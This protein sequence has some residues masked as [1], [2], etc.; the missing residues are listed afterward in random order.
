M[1][2]IRIRA[3]RDM[4]IAKAGIIPASESEQKGELK[5]TKYHLEDMRKLLKLQGD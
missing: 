5:A 4:A 2:E 1:A 3:Y